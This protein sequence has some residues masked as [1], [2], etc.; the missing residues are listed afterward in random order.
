MFEYPESSIL[1]AALGQR[2]GVVVTVGIDP[3]V[4]KT[5]SG[6]DPGAVE[7]AVQEEVA[8]TSRRSNEELLTPK[9]VATLFRVN[10]KTVSRWAAAGKIECMITPGGHRRYRSAEVHALLRASLNSSR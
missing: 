3:E 7:V 5:V 2:R 4:G 8:A 6:I 9:Q 10:P 1:R